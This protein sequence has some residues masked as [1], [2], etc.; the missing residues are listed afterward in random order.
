MRKRSGG[1]EI[2]TFVYMIPNVGN[3]KDVG[4]LKY[5]LGSKVGR[6][7]H[8]TCISQWQNALRVGTRVAWRRQ[9][10]RLMIMNVEVLLSLYVHFSFCAVY[11]LFS[12]NWFNSFFLDDG[13][14]WWLWMLKYLLSLYY[15]LSFCAVVFPF[16]FNWFISFFLASSFG[17]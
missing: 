9:R 7:N 1:N 16:S 10:R 5:I 14:D 11:F 17:Y 13:D 3:L 4:S 12:F 6:P 8:G 2:C 15:H